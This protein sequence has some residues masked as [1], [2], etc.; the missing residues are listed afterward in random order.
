MTASLPSGVT[1]TACGG[2]CTV[3]SMPSSVALITGGDCDASMTTRLSGGAG[4]GNVARPSTRTNL[5]SCADTMMSAAD[6][7]TGHAAPAA[8]RAMPKQ[9]CMEFMIP[10]AAQADGYEVM[11]N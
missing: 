5:P 2:P 9:R 1:A 4:C 7:D 3:C 6:A 10:S 11:A 8:N